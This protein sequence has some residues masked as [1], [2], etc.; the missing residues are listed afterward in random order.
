MLLVW[1]CR[2]G[3]RRSST[4]D[5]GAASEPA[6]SLVLSS[7]EGVEIWFT[8]TRNAKATDGTQCQERALEIRRGGTRVQ[9]P[10]LYTGDP[11]VLL[12]DTTLRALLW[13]HC[14]AVDAYLVDL[15]SGRPVREK[16]GRSQ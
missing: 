8:L 9:V 10:L 4:S 11:P 2:S 15:R 6:E 5:T 16:V 1:G 7:R 3:E 12:D 13:N 14:K